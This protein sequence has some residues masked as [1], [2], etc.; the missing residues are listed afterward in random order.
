M[1]DIKILS[2]TGVVFVNPDEQMLCS[3]CKQPADFPCPV[4]EDLQTSKCKQISGQCGHL[5]H[6]HCIDNW[7]AEHQTCPLC[8]ES[9]QPK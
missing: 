3:I 9:W 1:P 5:F 7:I 6:V 8:S 2:W 4:C